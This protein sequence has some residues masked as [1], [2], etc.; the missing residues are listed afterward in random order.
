MTGSIPRGLLAGAFVLALSGWASGALPRHPPPWWK[1]E[2]VVKELGLTADQSA[3]I[4]KIFQAIRPELRQEYDEL[5][6]L[7]AKLSRLIEG[8]TLDEAGL[9]RQIDRVETA[10]ANANK[11]RSLMLWRMR[12]VLTADQ[13]VRLKA[14]QAKLERRQM[15]PDPPRQS[16]GG[17]KPESESHKRPNF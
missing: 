11:T 10:R 15:P 4:D 14:L 9:A 13:R 16:P 5:D 6:R 2:E 3:R 12:Q 8:D 7:E 17:S 1:S